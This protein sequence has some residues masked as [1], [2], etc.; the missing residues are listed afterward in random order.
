MLFKC[1]SYSRSYLAH[2]PMMEKEKKIVYANESYLKP[3]LG[4]ILSYMG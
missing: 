2:M 3:L 1:I 4:L